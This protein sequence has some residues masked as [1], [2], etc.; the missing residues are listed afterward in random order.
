MRSLL[1]LLSSFA[2]SKTYASCEC[3]QVNSWNDLQQIINEANAIESI[4]PPIVSLCPFTVGANQNSG[5][6]MDIQR[7][8]HI[9]CHKTNPTDRCWIRVEKKKCPFGQD[10]G[11][12]MV[13]IR[14]SKS[15]TYFNRMLL[16]AFANL[17][18]FLYA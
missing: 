17:P 11:R 12:K 6:I 4:S 14:S 2:I 7:S 9:K 5:T 1:I 10:C 18:F 13:Y 8:M 15:F 16:N 3:Q